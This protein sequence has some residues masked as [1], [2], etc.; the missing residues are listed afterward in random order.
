[1]IKN[2][3]T[4]LALA[5]M[6]FACSKTKESSDSQLSTA[7]DTTAK[8][9]VVL[10]KDPRKIGPEKS[11]DQITIEQNIYSINASENPLYGYWVG[12]FG[13]NKINIA[14]ARIE[15]DSIF[16][17]S[18][19]AGNFRAIKGTIQKTGED[20][21]KAVMREPGDDQYDGEFQFEVDAARQE[22]SGSWKPYK[23]TV[24]AK[25]YIL[26]K[27]DFTYDPTLGD[28]PEASTTYLDV[29]DVENLLPEEI[30]MIR[31]EIY[32]RHGYSFTN[33]KIRRIFDEKD[34]Y[35]PMA[36]DI[37][38]QLTDIEAHNID[39]LLNYEEYQEEYYNDYG[40]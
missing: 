22:L 36:I 11:K 29:P 21:Y 2:T 35:I 34:W 30:E 6:L 20:I 24:G 12:S 28:H 18:V 25:T 27:T 32:A 17:H 39:L 37:R 16:G 8:A 15:G 5:L 13:K 38:D 40:R 9:P 26:L 19:C 23:K 10:A 4:C 1:M 14:I 3:C 31:N 33:I 7:P